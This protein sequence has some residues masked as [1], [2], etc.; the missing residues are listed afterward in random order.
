VTALPLV[1]GL[2]GGLALGLESG[3]ANAAALGAPGAPPEILFHAD[4]DGRFAAPSCGRTPAPPDYAQLVGGL[5]AERERAQQKGAPAPVVLLG[6]NE[7]AP[8][9]FARALLDGGAAGARVV[10]DLL[11]RA[12]Y[13][14]VALGHHE[15]ALEPTVLDDLLRALAARALPVVA[16]NLRCDA[17]SRSTCGL[18][19]PDVVI[20]RGAES[21]GVLATISPDVWAEIAPAARRGL[22]LDDPAAA[23]RAGVLRL[24]ARGATRVVLMTQGPRDA[25]AVDSVEALLRQLAGD[26]DPR[27]S[28]P[29]LV[30]AGGVADEDAGRALRLLRREGL[31]PI[32]GSPPGTRGFA[33]I[34]FPTSPSPNDGTDAPAEGRADFA[35]DLLSA[36]VGPR[37][38]GTAEALRR[39]TEA[40][41]ARYG[42][43]LL[44]RPLDAALTREA[45][46]KLLLEM[47]RRRARAEIALVNR[48]AVRR[49]PFPM[50]GRLTEADLEDALAYAAVIGVATVPGATVDGALGPTLANPKAAL[51]GLTRGAGGLEVN[52]R[53]LDKARAYRV[54]TIDFVSQG[55]DGIVSAGVLAW[56]ALP[57]RPELRPSLEAFLREEA[58]ADGAAFDAER[59]L[60]PP[61]ADRLL[62]V[63]LTD[64]DLDFAD[65]TIDNPASYGDAQLA[66]AQQTSIAGEAIGTLQLRL[67]RHEDDTRLDLKYGWART[68]AA[69][70]NMPLVS[71]ETADLITFTSVYSYRGLRARR[72]PP[73]VAVPDPYAR[74]WVESEF[75][76]PDVTPTQPRTYHHLQAQATAGAIFTLTPKL[77]VRGGGGARRELL[78][79]GDDGRWQ[80]VLE[81]GATLD[82]TAI[83]TFGALALKLEGMIDY[84]FVDPTEVRDHELR[85]TGKLSVPLVPLVF[86]TIGLDVYAVERERQGW[87]AAYDTTVGLR[88]HL[89]AAHQAL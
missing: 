7:A 57:D 72:V 29:D 60:G 52:G 8:A 66:R 83:A 85:G 47:M 21:I 4:L 12:G 46:T 75:T 3:A 53:P 43:P 44:A 86:V 1:I 32:V 39:P 16:S 19:R 2:A 67:P 42:G 76:R 14:A 25:R 23:V 48:G 37:D 11:T 40:Y 41:C 79:S 35:V 78:A 33:R 89:D 17:R 54:A 15:L 64:L 30:L 34:S 10:A 27:G 31:P 28:L 5:V 61:A 24:R 6:G 81:A 18:T 58:S 74:A 63:G 84:T 59:G 55:G 87:A 20:Q 45:F 49:A 65:T 22:S 38:L 88:I 68:Q 26:R 56:S 80:S 70:A 51:A 69:G 77:K 82:P 73:R 36:R 9:P 50:S 71:A 62:V 13:D